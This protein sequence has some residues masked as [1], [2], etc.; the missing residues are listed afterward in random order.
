MMVRIRKDIRSLTT[1]EKDTL[2]R[3]WGIIADNP[4]DPDPKIKSFFNIAGFHGEPFRGAGYNNSQWWGGYCHHGNVLFPTWH[5]AYLLCLEEALGKAVNDDNFALPYWNQLDPT[6][7][8]N[9][10]PDILLHKKY[11]YD[12]TTVDID[13]PLYSYSLSRAIYDR[14][15]TFP[16]ADYS[17]YK[18]YKTV[19]YPFSGLVGKEDLKATEAHNALMNQLNEL[20]ARMTWELQ[21]A[22]SRNIWLPC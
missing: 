19:R 17:K 2:I 16:D 14:L 3:A 22:G 4:P 11:R 13:N 21:C 20:G 5:R 8:K 6:Y 7:E 18:G 15:S 10:I 9:P 12:G 1:I